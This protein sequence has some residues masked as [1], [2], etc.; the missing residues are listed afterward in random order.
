M[1]IGQ[2]SPSLR[3][4]R[5]NLQKKNQEFRGKKYFKMNKNMIF[6]LNIA[7]NVK[8]RVKIRFF[9]GKRV[10]I[11]RKLDEKVGN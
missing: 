9:K 2:K 11:G 7:E 4:K 3:R 5:K 8:K 6:N 10:N 1:K